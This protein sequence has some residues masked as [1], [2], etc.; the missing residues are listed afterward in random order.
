MDPSLRRN[1][2]RLGFGEQSRVDWARQLTL[3]RPARIVRPQR[4]WSHH[5]RTIRRLRR[6]L[7]RHDETF[8]APF[9]CFQRDRQDASHWSQFTG[10][11]QLS[12]DV[13]VIQFRNLVLLVQLQHRERNWKIKARP[14]LADGRGSQINDNLSA[15]P[16]Q[17]AVAKRTQNP[18]PTLFDRGIRQTNDCDLSIRSPPGMHFN[19]DLESIHPHYC[20]RI[21]LRWHNSVRKCYFFATFARI[22]LLCGVLQFYVPLTP[23]TFLHHGPILGL[24]LFPFDSIS[25]VVRKHKSLAQQDPQFWEQNANK[26]TPNTLPKRYRQMA[27]QVSEFSRTAK[28]ESLRREEPEDRVDKSIDASTSGTMVRFTANNGT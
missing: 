16:P 22:V 26:P 4:D 21:D 24:R 18:I 11:R 28:K 7:I 25:V 9:A 13:A 17:R 6:I 5:K 1:R 23:Q 12:T 19:L 20:C 3:S 2:I 10:K 8:P 14:L 27:S 15:W